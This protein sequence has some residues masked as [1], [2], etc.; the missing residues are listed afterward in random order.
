MCGIAA[1][2]AYRSSAPDPAALAA[3]CD[4]MASRGP[5]AEGLWTGLDGRVGLGHRRLSIIDLSEGGAQPMS[6]DDE[7]VTIVF[8]GEIYNYEALKRGLE[9]RGHVFRS[10]SDTEVLLR[11]YREKGETFVEDLRGM[12]AFALWDA[13]R[14]GLLLARDPYGIK[15]LYIADDGRKLRAAS[16]V[17]ALLA[18]GGVD[19]EPDPAGHAGFFLWGHIPE[20]HTLYRGIRA[21]PAGHTQWIDGDG[22]RSP[23]LFASITDALQDGERTAPPVGDPANLVR[24]ALVDSVRAHLVADV[25]VGVFLSAGLD[26]TALAGLAAE[27]GGQLRT[28]TLGFEEYAGTPNDEVPLAESVAAFYGAE[29]RTVR[30]GADEFRGAFGRF[31]DAMDQPTLD[32]LNSYLVSHAAAQSG[33]KVALSGLG[34][35]ELFGGY[36]SFREIPR[37][38]GALGPVPGSAAIGRGLRAVAAPLIARAGTDRVPPKLAGVIEY[39]G[40]YGGA[41]LLRRGLFMPWELPDVLGPDLARAGW[42]ALQPLAQLRETVGAIET[43]R[44]KVTALESAHYMRSQLLRDTDWA[45]MAHS[46]EVRTP[47]VDWALLQRMAPL[48][49]ANPGVGKQTMA[50]AARPTLPPA[51]T[52]RPKTGFTTPVRQWLVESGEVSAAD[53]GLRGWAKHVYRRQTGAAPPVPSSAEATAA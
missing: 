43:P 53:R 11:L 26:S 44:L 52:N 21:F 17:K 38:V 35:D 34:G 15:P 23:R 50:A 25:P 3:A 1:Q 28:V 31:M 13:E 27:A 10:S 36:P 45:S 6:A 49:A 51:I 33:L 40:E 9:A 5:D 4:R 2:F 19:T 29:H 8:N 37:L 41:Y 47:L 20:P 46:L 18:M 16:Q 14:G 48:L 42:E 30:V 32:G 7:A 24:E 39:G 22:A 12:F